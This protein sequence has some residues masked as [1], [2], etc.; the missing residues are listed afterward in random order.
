MIDLHAH[1]LPGIDDGPEDFAE[2]LQM[3][4]LAH[5]DG[6]HTLVA[7]PH[8]NPGV[9]NSPKRIILAKLAEL[10]QK[11]QIQFSVGEASKKIDLKILAGAD[12]HLSFFLRQNFSWED[13]IFINENRQYLLLELPDYFLVEPIKKFIASFR[14]KGIIPIISHPERNSVFQKDSKILAD[15]VRLGAL[16]QITAMS[17]TGFFGQKAKEAAFSF[18]RQ[19]L[20]HLLA[21]DAHSSKSRPPILSKALAEIS[22][23]IG[24]EKAWRMVHDFPLAIIEGETIEIPDPEI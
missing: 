2:S 12:I 11:L 20:A 18:L 24:P 14:E 6:I 4:Q 15:F 23:H 17:I 16:S 5:A 7:T 13:I 3:C 21:S 22:A 19:N 1:I 8:L 10:N 9:Y